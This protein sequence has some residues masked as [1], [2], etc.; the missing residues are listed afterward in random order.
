MMMMKVMKISIY[1]ISNNSRLL[2]KIELKIHLP[3][4]TI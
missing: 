2:K 4:L 1:Y 3:L